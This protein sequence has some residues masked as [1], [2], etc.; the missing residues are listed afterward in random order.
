MKNIGIP[1]LVS[2]LLALFLILG[3]TSG[4]ITI[5]DSEGNPVTFEGVILWTL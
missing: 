1:L 2:L 4:S 5:H 3:F